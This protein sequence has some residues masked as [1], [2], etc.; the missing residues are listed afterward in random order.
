MKDRQYTSKQEKNK[1]WST[2]NT[3]KTDDRTTQKGE[4]K[5]NR[6]DLGWSV[7][8]PPTDGLIFKFPFLEKNK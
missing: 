7:K 3:L 6:D 5:K 2:N 1:Q 4:D 8:T